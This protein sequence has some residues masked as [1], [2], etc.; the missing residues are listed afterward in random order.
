MAKDMHK[1][2]LLPNK[3]NTIVS[4]FF[5]W[6][7][8]VGRLLIILT[9]TL[10]LCVFLYRFSLD[11]KIADLHDQI[12]IQSTIV[13]NFQASEDTFRNLH[14]R[15]A[16]AKQYDN[17]GKEVPEA[18]ASIVAMGQGKVTFKSIVITKTTA[19]IE[20]QAGSAADLSKF[21]NAL[22]KYPRA[23]SVKVD[24]VTNNPARSQTVVQIAIILQP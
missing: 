7:I 13:H 2:N 18:L 4:N 5:A 17:E 11:M 23:T 12:K 24:N 8:T 3:G 6:V 21:V 19:H 20:A 15:I 10:A 9:E 22:K 14:N 1:I 16:F